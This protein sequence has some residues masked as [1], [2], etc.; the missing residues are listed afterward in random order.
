[1][2][3]HQQTEQ[4]KNNSGKHGQ[5]CHMTHVVHRSSFS[6]MLRSKPVLTGQFSFTPDRTAKPCLQG[7]SCR[8]FAPSCIGAGYSLMM[9][10]SNCQGQFPA[11]FGM[12]R[13][14]KWQRRLSVSINRC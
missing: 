10:P 3:H 14:R 12:K 8:R 5:L 6:K 1:M 9:G 11:A 7:A 2:L 13:C 4:T